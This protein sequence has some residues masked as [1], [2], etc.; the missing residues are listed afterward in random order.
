MFIIEPDTVIPG[1]EPPASPA[2]AAAV[3][4]P[5]AAPEPTEAEAL[6]AAMD[7]GIA[8]VTPAAAIAPDPVDPVTPVPGAEPTQAEK[9]AA[10]IAAAKGTDAKPEPDKDT[11]AE[12]TTLGL[13]EKAAERFRGMASEIKA[14]AP[15][16]AQL[17]AAGIKDVA[18]LPRLVKQAK[19]G[20]DL[21]QMVT[22]TGATA[23]EFG[24][25]LDYI[26]L[27]R[28]VESGDMSSA[29]KAFDMVSE[30]LAS[31]SKILGKEVP[32]VHDPLAGHADLLADIESGELS[33]A[34]ALEL[35][36]VRQ[37]KA[38][39]TTARTNQEQ[40]ATQ[41]QAQERAIN[42]GKAAINAF[43]QATAAADPHYAAKRPVLNAKVAEI[44]QKYPPH[45][46]ADATRLAYEAIPNPAPA[47]AAKPLPGPVRPSGPRPSMTQTTFDDPF[48]AMD[49]G[50]AAASG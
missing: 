16:K 27:I 35:A 11:E 4:E 41:H 33:R 8:A 25:Q 18:E 38:A 37:Q 45:L 24:R 9:D 40:Q 34:R 43:D 13:K 44:R 10:A 32:G 17:D 42:D 47:P 29:Q 5:P 36:S 21:I 20:A 28:K 1:V 23:N 39:L 14:L 12:I 30:E 15:I 3:I 46:W 19:D 7:E 26:S 48:A 22:S 2:E 6:S 49:A 50:I 31:L